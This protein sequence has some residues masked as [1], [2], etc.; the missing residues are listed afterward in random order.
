MRE[1]MMSGLGR[2]FDQAWARAALV[3]TFT[4][5]LTA[6]FTSASWAQARYKTLYRFTNTGNGPFAGLVADLQGNLYGTTAYGGTQNVGTVFE[7]APNGHGGWN[8]TMLHSF[9]G[10]DGGW[11]EARLIFDATGN[12]Y[13][14]T[15]LGG[16]HK[17]GTVF[18][19]APDGHGGWT[20][21]V[22][23]SFNFSCVDGCEPTAGLIFDAAGNLYGTTFEGGDSNTHT[24]TVFELSPDGHGVWTETVLHSFGNGTD[25]A[26]PVG[27]L[28]FDAAGNLY[29]TTEIGGASQAGTVFELAPDGHG[30]W[31]GTVLH[32]FNGTDGYGPQATLIFDAAGNLYG[33][34][35]Y[36]GDSRAGTVFELTPDG[37]GGWKETV[38]H[39]FNRKDG[40]EP[41]AGLIFDAAG[42]LYGTTRGGGANGY[43]RVFELA[44]NGQGGWTET[45]LHTFKDQPGAVPLGT[46]IFG[47]QGHLYGTTEGD[48][49]K[50]WGSV[51]EITP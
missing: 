28:I 32:S 2:G 25:G 49:L 36:G 11:P 42:N 18:E 33:T 6:S 37:H 47:T 12:L 44:P 10:S 7:L 50:T 3:A 26:L 27:G 20:E 14:T 29:G 22:L 48:L 34:T 21:T 31:T 30:G 13:G 4:L 19:L 5:A 17:A 43:G 40:R 45:V 1:E 35:Q 51:F 38:L 16:A 15:F 9:N 46:L 23:H 39:S 8:H 24:G 41:V